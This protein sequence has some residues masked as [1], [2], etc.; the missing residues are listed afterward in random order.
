MALNVRA[1]PSTRD[2]K[3][4]LPV[5][6]SFSQQAP[7]S[8]ALQ[9]STKLIET[10]AS[11][12]VIWET[13]T[14][15]RKPKNGS[16]VRLLMVSWMVKPNLLTS[17]QTY[18]HSSERSRSYY[19][20]NIAIGSQDNSSDENS[21]VP[22]HSR[23]RMDDVVEDTSGVLSRPLHICTKY[24]NSHYGLVRCFHVLVGKRRERRTS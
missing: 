15:T 4:S 16:P 19:I 12:R 3:E 21:G 22:H 6:P 17:F 1:N 10:R 23:S 14:R 24:S 8:P 2:G 5:Y 13:T 11:F 18:P 9:K 20:S 7:S